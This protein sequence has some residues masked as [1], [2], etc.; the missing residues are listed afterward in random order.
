[1]MDLSREF[2]FFWSGPFS[3]WYPCKFEISG[4][5][6]N[7]AEQYM[8][9]QK[10]LLFG[11]HAAAARIRLAKKPREQKAIG[12]TVEHFEP[13]RWGTH[14]RDIV[15]AGNWAKFSQNDDLKAKLLK[16]GGTILVE[17]SPKD[18]IWGIGLGEHD[19]RAL[20]QSTWRGSNWL[21][22]VLTAVR[23]DIQRQTDQR[24]SGALPVPTP[25]NWI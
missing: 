24:P 6:Y 21:G 18:R 1:M 19:P 2:T 23:D 16:T 7:C 8:M 11:D 15:Y 5:M 9:E 17:A 4:F 20:V 3:Q 13:G 12:R 25:P 14:A 10:A 22:Q